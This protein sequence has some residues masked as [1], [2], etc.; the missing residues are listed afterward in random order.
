[1]ENLDAKSAGLIAQ[2]LAQ[3]LGA[4]VS[5]SGAVD[6]VS[7]GQNIFYVEGGSPLM[8]KITGTGCLLSAMLGGYAGANPDRRLLASVAALS[9]LALAGERAAESGPAG[10]GGFRVR[11]FDHLSLIDGADLMNKKGVSKNVFSR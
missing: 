4:L 8:A 5:I 6:V 3:R 11:L 9:H 2:S 1:M 10:L 7:D